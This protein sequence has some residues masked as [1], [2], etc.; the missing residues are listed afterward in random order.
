MANYLFAVQ[1]ASGRE[2]L[3]QVIETKR[4]SDVSAQVTKGGK[5]EIRQKG[6]GVVASVDRVD[7]GE[8]TLHRW[9]ADDKLAEPVSH[10][11]KRLDALTE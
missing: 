5:L 3:A 6:L 4:V 9:E 2:V 8:L 10:A 1:T 11:V 7:D